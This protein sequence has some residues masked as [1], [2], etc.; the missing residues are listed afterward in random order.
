[1]LPKGADEAGALPADTAQGMGGPAGELPQVAGAQVGQLMLFPVTPEV[2]HRVEFRGIGWKT[3]H[4]DFA[5]QTFQILT[6]PSAAVGGHAVPDDEQ[7]A[8]HVTLQVFQEVDHLLGL[9]RTGIEAKV[10]VPPR[11]TGDGGELLPVEVELQDRG[12]AFGTPGAHPVRL[13]AQAAFVDEEERAPFGFGFFLMR[14]HST[15]F[16]RAISS[17]LR[18]RARPVGRWQLQPICP[19]SR[20]IWSRW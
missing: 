7:T 20:P 4:P 10:K 13:L 3:L 19:S 12:L 2:L 15:R 6:H 1:L 14:G 9:D 16:Q 11:E 17:S 8:L 5:V 18:S